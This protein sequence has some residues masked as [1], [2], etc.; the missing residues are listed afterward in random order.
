LFYCLTGRYKHFS[1][2]RRHAPIPAPPAPR[3]P[4]QTQLFF[5]PVQNPTNTTNPYFTTLTNNHQ[6]SLTKTTTKLPTTKLPMTMP[7]QTTLPALPITTMNPQSTMITRIQIMSTSTAPPLPTTPSTAPQKQQP[8]RTNKRL[9]M[10]T[11]VPP[12]S[13]GTTY[14]L[15]SLSKPLFFRLVL[16]FLVLNFITNTCTLIII[17]YQVITCQMHFLIYFNL[18]HSTPPSRILNMT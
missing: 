15:F 9:L 10:T 17:I 11:T 16:L 14:I 8:T 1:C 7:L 2:L 3:L 12:T 4:S 18:P 6:K 13:S 5:V